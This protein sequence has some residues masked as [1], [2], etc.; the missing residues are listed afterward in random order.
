MTNNLNLLRERKMFCF[1]TSSLCMIIALC[2]MVFAI[3][4]LSVY[5]SEFFIHKDSILIQ[6][7]KTFYT[8]NHENYTNVL[9]ALLM[10]M[11]YI[12]IIVLFIF[13]LHKSL[14]AYMLPFLMVA[15]VD[16]IFTFVTFFMVP[17][18]VEN[19]K[20]W[21]L[22]QTWIPDY[23][24]Q[25]LP[26]KNVLM[27]YTL[28]FY[29]VIITM[30]LVILKILWDGYSFIRKNSRNNPSLYNYFVNFRRNARRTSTNTTSTNDNITSQV[31]ISESDQLPDYCKKNSQGN[32]PKFFKKKRRV[33]YNETSPSVEPTTDGSTL[34]TYKRYE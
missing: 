9:F 32:G 34:P 29:L 30:R 15:L 19:I 33:K 13:G 22:Y 26:C 12:L 14:A 6:S 5:L 28:I 3:F 4:D 20:K 31:F 25:N 21:I 10:F 1:K 16:L 2:Y 11:A 23:I 17:S 27:I 8:L 7:D 18:S 24:K